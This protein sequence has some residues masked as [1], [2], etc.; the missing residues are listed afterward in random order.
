MGKPG[1]EAQ[2]DGLQLRLRTVD[3]P[4]MA[5]VEADAKCPGIKQCLDSKGRR[6]ESEGLSGACISDPC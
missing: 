5:T 6:N 4:V 2:Q 1:D 3:G